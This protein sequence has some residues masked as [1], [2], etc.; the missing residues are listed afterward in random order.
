VVAI[1]ICSSWLV[2]RHRN[3]HLKR[4]KGPNTPDT[5]LPVEVASAS[6]M[7]SVSTSD[8]HNLNTS[9]VSLPRQNLND[10]QTRARSIEETRGDNGGKSI[11]EPGATDKPA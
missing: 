2:F 9:T 11:L 3:D 6:F 10:T 8:K 5:D 7:R 4:V 1:I